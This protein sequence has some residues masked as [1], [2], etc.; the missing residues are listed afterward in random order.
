[1]TPG[2]VRLLLAL[3]VFVAFCGPLLFCQA[4]SAPINLDENDS[5][6]R[7]RM[8]PT[9]FSESVASWYAIDHPAVFRW[10]DA[11]VL[12]A[13]DVEIGK[14]PVVDPYKPVK[15]SIENGFAAPRRPVMF[16]RGAGAASLLGAM[17]LLF[18]VARR[19]LGG[20]IWGFVVAI[21]LVLPGHIGLT[22]GGYL[23]TDAYLAFFLALTLLVWLRFHYSAAPLSYPRV[24]VMGLVIGLAVSTKINAGLLLIAYL[25]YVFML[26]SGASRWL[27][28]FVVL[29]ASL[30]VFVAVNPIMWQ[31]GPVWWA[32][33]I[34]RMLKHR[35]NVIEVHKSLFGEHAFLNRLAFMLPMWYLLPLM[36]LLVARMRHEKWFLPVTLWAA[37][38]VAGTALTANQPFM[39]YRMPIEM[40][41]AVIMVLSAVTFAVR[42]SR[43][44]WTIGDLFRF[45]GAKAVASPES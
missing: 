10:I 23:F 43:G 16:L 8:L 21:P 11:A 33:V 14:V 26:S 40:A 13:F 35:A 32:E 41:L 45:R 18:L 37:L 15:W 42:L 24:A 9:D 31:G 4:L 7:T 27:K 36:A 30:A 6:E 39:R 5:L 1:M 17:I 44:E 28:A 2:R 34:G 12:R 19:A 29:S 22:V 3:L 20:C 38:L 25:I